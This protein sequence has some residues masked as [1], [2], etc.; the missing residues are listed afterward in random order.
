MKF[1]GREGEER[2]LSEQTKFIDQQLR[3]IPVL[4]AY[5]SCGLIFA[6]FSI[7]RFTTVVVSYHMMFLITAVFILGTFFYVYN[8]ILNFERLRN[9]QAVALLL[10]ENP[11]GTILGRLF[12]LESGGYPVFEVLRYFGKK[13]LLSRYREYLLLRIQKL[14][15]E[16]DGRPQK[17][18]DGSLFI[19][20]G[21]KI[22]SIMALPCFLP[23]NIPFVEITPPSYNQDPGELSSPTTVPILP[24]EELDNEK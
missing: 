9:L 10:A 24:R 11:K 19:T 8:I 13:D 5:I 3:H 21:Q 12:E 23:K 1:F 15:Q 20:I 16:I 7:N 14:Q 17:E 2:S 22:N 18:S 4:L 6:G